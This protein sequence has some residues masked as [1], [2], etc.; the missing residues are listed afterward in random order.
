[1][2]DKLYNWQKSNSSDAPLNFHDGDVRREMSLKPNT[3][4]KYC[5]F[6]EMLIRELNGGKRNESD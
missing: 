4:L 3:Y 5:V 1:M 2:K 6:I